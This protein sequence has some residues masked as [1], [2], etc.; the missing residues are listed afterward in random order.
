VN[1]LRRSRSFLRR[2]KTLPLPCGRLRR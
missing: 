1:S 2:Q